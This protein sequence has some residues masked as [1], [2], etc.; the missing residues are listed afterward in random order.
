MQ[1]DGNGKAKNDSGEIEFKNPYLVVGFDNLILYGEF[2][3]GGDHFLFIGQDS[4]GL[5][6]KTFEEMYP[7][8]ATPTIQNGTNTKAN[9]TGISLGGR[10][11]D[12]ETRVDITKVNNTGIGLGSRFDDSETR[13]DITKVPLAAMSTPPP[14]IRQSKPSSGQTASRSDTPG[15][16]VS[17]DF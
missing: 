2:H 10:F 17:K 4:D 3:E 11:D 15:G 14:L 16:L 12:S 8:F 5:V 13:F 9:T 7:M 6:P 1:Q